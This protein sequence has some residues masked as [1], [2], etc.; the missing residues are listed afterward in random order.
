MKSSQ[1]VP[2]LLAGLMLTA[3]VSVP[4]QAPTAPVQPSTVMPV[5][6]VTDIDDLTAVADFAAKQDQ[7]TLFVFDI[8][9]TVLTAE[10]FFGS[11][12]W[13]EWQKAKDL[14][15]EQQVKCKFDYIALNYEAQTM[16]PTQADAPANF[17][18][19]SQ[20][21]LFLTSRSGNYRGATERELQRNGYNFPSALNG[22]SEGSIWEWKSADGARHA[23][24]S[25]Y[26]GVFMTS[27][28]DKGV[29]LLHLLDRLHLRDRFDR[30]VLVDDGKA[31]IDNMR[32]ALAAARVPY[33][34]FHYIRIDKP[35]P[36]N[37]QL[38]EQAESDYDR[39]R[40]YLKEVFPGRYE[41]LQA[42][43]CAY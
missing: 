21:K 12:Y 42:G 16:K 36:I 3:C 34:G 13:Y 39:S 33:Q 20:P 26:H 32:N 37:P 35:Q 9:D 17:N 29:M 14:P 25:Y 4:Q 27:G 7:R 10:Q 11:D 30:V 22:N 41:E 2:V 19:V 6:V 18:G 23:T 24:L 43:R 31:N 5:S 8:D 38:A 15:N 28:Q 1:L 40:S